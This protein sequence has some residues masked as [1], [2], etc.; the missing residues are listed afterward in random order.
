MILWWSPVIFS[1]L[2]RIFKKLFSNKQFSS[3]GNDSA[4]VEGL[5]QQFDSGDRTCQCNPACFELDY[6]ISLSSATWPAN[7]YKVSWRIKG[8][9]ILISYFCSGESNNALWFLEF[10]YGQTHW[11]Q[12]KHRRSTW[13]IWKSSPDKS[14]LWQPQSEDCAGIGRLS[15]MGMC[16][17]Y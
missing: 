14:L 7:Q 3:S 10:K 16:I 13:F 2:V 5:M 1:L 4:C 6:E 17:K 12:W 15:F 8:T 9:L 11:K